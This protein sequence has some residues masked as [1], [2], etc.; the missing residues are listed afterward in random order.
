MSMTIPFLS[1]FKKVKDQALAKKESPSTPPKAVAPLEKPSSERFSKTVMPN[2]I[3]TLAPQDPCEM[4]ARSSAMS[5]QMQGATAIAAPP[6][7][8]RTIAFGASPP[9]ASRP[10]DLPPAVALALEPRVERVISLD[11]ADIA[12]QIP[13]DY[14][15]PIESIDGTRRI[16][17]KASEVERGMATGKPAVS[18]ATVYQ[19][20]PEIF[21]RS[22]AAGDETQVQ[23]PFQKVLDQF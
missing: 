2:A 12:A 16:L 23:L 15:K 20:V 17:L 5:G 11:L 21:L 7:A 19:Q 13:R 8:P 10:S 22:I 3:R 4:A 14:I 18:L 1:F 6:S 9:A